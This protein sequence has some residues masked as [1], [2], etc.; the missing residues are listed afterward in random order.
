M[1]TPV[2]TTDS[3]DHSEVV[4]A[5]GGQVVPPGDPEA[6]ARAMEATLIRKPDRDAIRGT[7]QKALS[8]S[9]MVRRTQAVYE[10]LLGR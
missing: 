10:Q 2:V 1:G 7:A 5:S 8:V 3:G 9:E 6:L 4:R